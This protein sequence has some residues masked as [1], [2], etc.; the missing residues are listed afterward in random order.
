[1]KRREAIAKRYAR[2]LFLLARERGLEETVGEE[3]RTGCESIFARQELVDF[4][5]RPWIKGETKKS[6][7][8]TVAETARCSTLVTEFLGL[9]AARG[10][11]DHLPEIVSVYRQFVD[12]VRARARAEVRCAV[13]LTEGDRE[14]LSARLG[15]VVGKQVLVEE[16]ADSTLLGGFVAQVGS[17]L[18]D[19]SLDGQLTRL[20]ERL[21]RG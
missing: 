3:L 21:V 13:P 15:R 10:R 1:M 5:L 16:A 11:L 7:I 20:R 4:L 9:L 12:E 2:A 18:L 14:A 17:L 19:G 6:V 8:T